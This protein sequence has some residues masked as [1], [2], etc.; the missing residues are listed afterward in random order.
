MNQDELE[1]KLHRER[2]AK[3]LLQL[4]QAENGREPRD[5]E[6]LNSWAASPKARGLIHGQ[7]DEKGKVDPSYPNA[8]L[9]GGD[10]A[11][12]TSSSEEREWKKGHLAK[13][14]SYRLIVT[15][16]IRLQEIEEL[17]KHLELEKEMLSD[18]E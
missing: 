7:L 6:D 17:I 16:N 2:E 11:V 13:D 12:T 15:G 14:V 4:F 1:A 3:R 5:E 8:T 18:Q 9:V 10:P